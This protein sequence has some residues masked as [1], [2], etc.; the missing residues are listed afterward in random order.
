MRNR[1][2]SNEG[3]NKFY[4]IL[5]CAWALAALPTRMG[6]EIYRAR[7]ICRLPPT[8]S[9]WNDVGEFAHPLSEN[10]PGNLCLGFFQARHSEA[11]GFTNVNFALR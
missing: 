10:K 4:I 8:I 2:C 6:A 5:P 3:G 9:L 1:A 7:M 11:D